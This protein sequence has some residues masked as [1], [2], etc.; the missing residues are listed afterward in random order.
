MFRSV[1]YPSSKQQTFPLSTRLFVI[2]STSR[3]HRHTQ[4]NVPKV[5]A[6]CPSKSP[7]NVLLDV[8]KNCDK[9]ESNVKLQPGQGHEPISS[10]KHRTAIAFIRCPKSGAISL[11]YGP[12]TAK[13]LSHGLYRA[14][15]Q[16]D[17]LIHDL[18]PIHGKAV[19]TWNTSWRRI[20]KKELKKC[21]PFQK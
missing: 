21:F 14:L 5:L 19:Q 6:T 1:L 9:K 3:Q 15:P 13:V 16:I 4:D 18:Q 20:R 7:R 12:F 2:S 11:K 10:G 8:Q 17:R